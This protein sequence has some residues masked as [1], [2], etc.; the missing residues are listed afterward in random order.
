MHKVKNPT[1]DEKKCPRH[2]KF[3][4]SPCLKP[5]SP[6]K[7]EKN[8]DAELDR[9]IGLVA[10]L[11][12]NKKCCTPKPEKSKNADIDRLIDIIIDDVKNKKNNNINTEPECE[13]KCNS[14]IAQEKKDEPAQI[15]DEKTEKPAE[16]KIEPNTNEATVEKKEP[17]NAEDAAD[18]KKPVDTPN[19][20]DIIKK[21][22]NKE[23]TVENTSVEKPAENKEQDANVNVLLDAVLGQ[24]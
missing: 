14:E 1:S 18:D 6:A 3:E 17:I 15:V 24:N 5:E 10:N 7:C 23:T 9:L 20:V 11:L 19:L 16:N 13:K 12:N 2:V 21:D 8:K 4:G 22:E